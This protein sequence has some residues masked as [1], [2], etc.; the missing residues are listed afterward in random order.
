MAKDVSIIIPIYNVAPYVEQ[1][2]KSVIN[3]TYKNLEVIIVDDCG[4]DNSMEIVEKVV[5]QI[6]QNS[7]VTFKILHH[8]KN[9]G[10]SAA[11]NTG[12]KAA[13]G[14]YLYFLDSDDWIIPECIEL[15]IDRVR[16]H[17]DSE[18]VFAGADVTTGEHK[19][20]DY[21]KKALPEYSN[22]RDWLQL[23][24]LRRYDFGMTAWNKLVS[25][26]F[27]LRNKLYFEEGMIHEDEVWNFLLSRYV[28]AASFV[29]RNT[30]CYNVRSQSITKTTTVDIRWQ[31]LFCVWDKMV[32]LI[33]GYIK[34]TQ[35]KAICTFI[36]EKT[37]RD[38]PWK[39]KRTL[40]LL[41]LKMALRVHNS[42]SPYLFIQGLF[43]LFY[44]RKY[45]NEKV[46]NRLKL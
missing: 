3:Q 12:I 7:Q 24:M 6:T 22:D 29:P 28:H 42:L 19:W 26:E 13:S 36:I 33:G 4:T 17:P 37:L 15:M 35:V 30:Y 27:V 11:R 20:L 46:L 14:E 9:R 2:I 25:R 1:C 21:T 43:A 31:R 38:F 18:I 39:Y 45:Y 41:F 44:Q 23:S 8:E 5:S 10:L 40:T 32:D 16:R 34:D